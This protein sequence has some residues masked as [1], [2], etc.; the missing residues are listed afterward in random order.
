LILED[1]NRW[2]GAEYSG[3]DG[4]YLSFV[5]EIQ[6]RGIGLKHRW[7]FRGF[8]FAI[9]LCISDV[10]LCTATFAQQ[11]IP[12]NILKKDANKY[13]ES[14]NY[15]DAA[16]H[17]R[18]LLNLDSQSA[19]YNLRYGISLFYSDTVRAQCI[20]YLHFA[21]EQ[22]NAS[23]DAYYYLAR[24]Y[25]INH[26]FDEALEYFEMYKART[27]SKAHNK[28]QIDL[29]MQM[30][31]NAKEY[32]QNP[33]DME[34]VKRN[35]INN[36]FFSSA[37]G[38]ILLDASIF[39]VPNGLRTA[40]DRRHSE[41]ATGCIYD[42]ENGMVYSSY[43]SSDKNGRD[44]YRIVQFERGEWSKSKKLNEKINT[45]Y[46]ENFP[47]V[48]PKGNVLYFS[49]NSDRS[50]GGLDIFRS[51]WDEL[52]QTWT[53]PQ[54]VGYPINT[55]HNEFLFVPKPKEQL[56]YFTS[57]RSSPFG[58]IEVFKI[59]YPKE[60]ITTAV[61][62]GRFLVA[63]NPNIT[64]AQITVID[65]HKNELS[66]IYNTDRKSGNYLIVLKPGGK[67]K[68][69]VKVKGFEEQVV[70]MEV[71][72]MDNYFLLRQLMQIERTDIVDR[73]SIVNYFT[74]KE[75]EGYE[76][77]LASKAMKESSAI[78]NEVVRQGE[79]QEASNKSDNRYE[80]ENK[81]GTN[82]PE[83]Q[84]RN[85]EAGSLIKLGNF[86]A[87]LEIYRE[88]RIVAPK[89]VQL[90]YNM[91]LCIFHANSNKMAAEPYFK[92]ASLSVLA[93]NETFYYLGRC[94]HLNEEYEKAKSMYERSK[95]LM[96]KSEIDEYNLDL[97]IANCVAA[98][99]LESGK[100]RYE[101]INSKTLSAEIVRSSFNRYEF[102]GKILTTIDDFRQKMDIK[103]GYN[104]TMYLTRDNHTIYYASYGKTGETGLDIYRRVRLFSGEWGPPQYLDGINTKYDEC[105]PFYTSD[106]VLYFSSNRESSIGGYDVY[107][108]KIRQDFYS[109][110]EPLNLGRPVNS[111]ADDMYFIW[112]KDGES[113]YFTSDRNSE[114]GLVKVFNIRSIK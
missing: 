96:A 53:P 95:K 109:W 45:V 48:T 112:C 63:G 39:A 77:S 27:T 91:G 14:E 79:V 98:P 84:K 71:P 73:L 100:L 35:M 107:K 108:S 93:P 99:K 28:Q 56:A 72:E 42:N 8:V 2:A 88:L 3:V 60:I 38:V 36:T 15:V 62:K 70:T 87:A 82:T 17:Y 61:I 46:D 90:N 1:R 5:R 7:L 4:L 105:Y 16:A 18:D 92:T 12:E 103:L 43:G 44:L 102:Y 74:Q 26:R 85:K 67:Y 68:F 40:E 19:E 49:S 97:L 58:K 52:T 65:L 37:Y 23:L 11:N 59:K 69:M 54:N 81:I 20:K 111:P 6:L 24:A 30:V 64:R 31:R 75:A 101:I 104:S 66:G 33:I 57:D 50:M 25:H 89:N 80:S 94:Y 32:V 86:K 83:F 113:G 78:V 114:S 110:T 106:G 13:F 34:V 10:F 76:Q 41:K 9:A 21:T 51:E 55:V 22:P 47:Y 29:Q